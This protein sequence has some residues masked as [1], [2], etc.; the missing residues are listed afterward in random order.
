MG[1]G[2]FLILLKFLQNVLVNPNLL[3]GCEKEKTNRFYW[4]EQLVEWKEE[5]RNSHFH[6]F[7][8][9]FYL[10]GPF[11]ISSLHS[12][13]GFDAKISPH[14]PSGNI[15][16]KLIEYKEEMYVTS[17]CGK[18]WRQVLVLS[19]IVS[20]RS[21]PAIEKKHFFVC[22]AGLRGG[23]SHPVPGPR[24]SHRCHQGHVYSSEDTQVRLQSSHTKTA[25]LWN[26]GVLKCV[27]SWKYPLNK[28]SR[29]TG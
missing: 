9:F 6:V 24:W 23:T 20:S 28:W 22:L 13:C 18:T 1:A 25:S 5:F 4:S 27:Y 14:L 3:S 12:F 21:E 17:D 16:S 29:S 15:G 2:R 11:L 8:L 19:G 7:C 10:L 26:H